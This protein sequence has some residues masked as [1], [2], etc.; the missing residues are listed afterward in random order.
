MEKLGDKTTPVEVIPLSTFKTWVISKREKG[1]NKFEFDSVIPVTAENKGR[2]PFV[3]EEL[4]DGTT[5]RWDQTLN[6]YVLLASELVEGAALPYVLSCRRTSYKAGKMVINHFTKMGMLKA[7][8]AAKTIKLGCRQE[9]NDQG[10]YYVLD[11][12]PGRVST[13][14]ELT[15]AHEWYKTLSMGTHKIDDSD[16]TSEAVKDVDAEGTAQY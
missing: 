5:V 8:A 7:P 16:L 4:A 11:V 3:D 6:F 9:K 15:T 12:L 10:H 1:A 13:K 14:D 2:D